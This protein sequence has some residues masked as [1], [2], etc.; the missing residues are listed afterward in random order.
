MEG[1]IGPAIIKISKMPEN[2]FSNETYPT[3]DLIKELCAYLQ[4]I[5]FTWTE[6]FFNDLEEKYQ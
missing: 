2:W 3:D 1:H 4:G 6:Y 5:K